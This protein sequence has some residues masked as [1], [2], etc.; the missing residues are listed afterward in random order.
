MIVALRLR[1]QSLLLTGEMI[2]RENSSDRESATFLVKDGV[3][4]DGP[5]LAYRSIEWY[6][7]NHIARSKSLT[8]FV[9]TLQ[10]VQKVSSM[11]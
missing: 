6:V 2:T 5:W 7:M 11:V 10:K 3:L 1:V 9:Q 4:G 8:H